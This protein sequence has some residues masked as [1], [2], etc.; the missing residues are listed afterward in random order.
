MQTALRD[1]YQDLELRLADTHT[2]LPDYTANKRPFV[3]RVLASAGLT[4]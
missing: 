2:H 1:E 3:A 4:L